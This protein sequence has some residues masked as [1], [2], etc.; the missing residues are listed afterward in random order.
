MKPTF[1]HII[2]A[3]KVL[4]NKVNYTPIIN[5]K[6]IGEDLGCNLYLKLE[7][8]QVTS[9]FKARGAFIAINKLTNKQKKQGVIAMSAGNHAQ[10]VAWH[11]RSL[12]IDST[13]IMPEQAP[14]SKVL[15]T[16]KLG[17]NIILRGR[18]LNEST[19]FVKKI[20]AKD[21][22]TLIHPYD[23]Y[24]VISGQGTIGLE[25][26]EKVK[27]ID[28]L[29]IPIGGGGLIS[30]ISIAAKTI[31]P[32]IKII[33]V[34]SKNFP[35]AYNLFYNKNNDYI[36]ETIADGIAVKIP[37][38]IA[39]PIIKKYVDEILLV[40]ELSIENSIS[41]LF[42]NERV[43]S[44]GAGATGVAAIYENKKFF[45]N[46]NVCTIICGGNIDSRLFAGI[47]NRKLSK[48]G[49]IARIRIDIN[50]EPGMLSKIANTIA[51]N[52]GNIIEIYHQ[53]MFHDVPVKQAKIDAI[54][55]SL[56]ID[57]IN[58]IIMNLKK[59]GFKVVILSDISKDD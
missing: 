30:G 56:S 31:N 50:D 32:S 11:A 12:G 47:L 40:D 37:G 17:A 48:D 23:D 39:T 28:I 42:E 59:D 43:I 10:A 45:K 58:K 2:K 41:N 25:I 52:G 51:K 34:E 8:L 38:L 27:S 13:I 22:S 36:G 9:S 3:S 18:T 1:E 44:E 15:R 16:R 55:E 53:R 33:G 6:T 24:D 19:D 7:S 21:G 4:K 57:H 20:S 35:S 26:L 14:Y 54:I 29:V 46:K 49:R 5:A